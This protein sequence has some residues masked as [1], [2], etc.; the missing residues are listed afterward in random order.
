METRLTGEIA[1]GKLPGIYFERVKF[2]ELAEDLLRDYRVNGKRSLG[3]AEISINHLK[4]S[5]G[6]LKVPQV[7]SSRINQHMVRAGTPERVAMMISGHKDAHGLRPLKHRERREPE[8]RDDEAG[9]VPGFPG[10]H[11]FG[12]RRPR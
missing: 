3:R 10:G 7:T 1:N 8:G 9:R 4:E 6:G 2:D 11:N 12:H 5:F